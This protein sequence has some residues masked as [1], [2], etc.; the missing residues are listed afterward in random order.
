MS[1]IDDEIII[2]RIFDK[3]EIIDQKID[4]KIDHL[5]MKITPKID[6]LC[7]RVTKVETI[8]TT[9]LESEKEKSEKKT[10]N[11]Y[12]IMAVFGGIVSLFEIARSYING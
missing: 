7:E 11:F 12:I 3:L 5:D 6:D 8:T 10:R 4:Q 2:S 9:H 1:P